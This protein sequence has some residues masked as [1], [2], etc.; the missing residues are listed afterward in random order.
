MEN[1][2]SPRKIRR[3]ERLISLLAMHGGASQVA[4]E[5]G[6]PKSHISALVNGTRGIGDKLAG[7]LERLYGKPT[8]WFDFVDYPAVAPLLALTAEEPRAAYSA[9]KD[10]GNTSV[11]TSKISVPLIS[12]IRAGGWGEID[13][14]NPDTSERVDIYRSNPSKYAFALTIDGDSMT[15]P[16]GVSFPDGCVVIFDPDRSPKAGDYVAAKD[17][18]TQRATFKRLMTDSGRWFLRPLNSGYPTIE[19]DDPAQRVIGVAIEWQLGGKL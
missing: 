13:D 4:L 18:V 6:T 1:I 11:V 5:S 14:H 9:T 2:E 7:K 19:I 10:H 17:V 3:K 8:G 16:T 12:W 15:A